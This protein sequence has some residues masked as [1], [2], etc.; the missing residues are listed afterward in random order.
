MNGSTIHGKEKEAVYVQFV[1]KEKFLK[2]RDPTNTKLLHLAEVKGVSA[3]ADELK[4]YL[5]RP[6]DLLKPLSEDVN[7]L[8]EKFISMCTDGASTNIG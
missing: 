2:G 8:M 4:A 6:F 5:G 3:N 1:Q 7:K